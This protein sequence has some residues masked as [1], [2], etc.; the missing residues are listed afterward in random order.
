MLWKGVIF[1]DFYKL[2][3]STILNFTNCSEYIKQLTWK[4]WTISILLL[5]LSILWSEYLYLNVN[6][7]V[8]LEKQF[9]KELFLK[10]FENILILLFAI[11]EVSLER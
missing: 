11:L 1:D 9:L 10:F 7:W 6:D 2:M 3:N 5:I 8:K 4:K